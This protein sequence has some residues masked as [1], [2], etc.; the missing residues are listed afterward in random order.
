MKLSS[1]QFEQNEFIPSRYTCDG[2]NINPPLIIE[3]APEEAQSLVLVMDDPDIPVEI[4]EKIGIKVFDHWIV[5]NIDPETEQIEENSLPGICG[6]NTRG[7]HEYTG[8]CPP[9]QYEP[10]VHRYFFKLYALDIMLN[11]KEGA[12]KKEIEEAMEGHIIAKAELV[13]KYSRV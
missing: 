9:P 6:S 5:F 11:L 2:D 12:T 10:K 13:G 4:K 8:P 3:N 1:P 7:D